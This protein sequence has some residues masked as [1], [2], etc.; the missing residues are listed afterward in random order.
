MC[1]FLETTVEKNH[2]KETIKTD[3]GIIFFST[4]SRL[5]IVFD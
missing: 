1:V 3:I 5:A 4:E 2:E